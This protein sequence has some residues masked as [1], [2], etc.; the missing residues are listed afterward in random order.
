[1][2]TTLCL[3]AVLALAV[4]PSCYD[5]PNTTRKA[6]IGAATGAIIGGVIGHQSGETAA[7]AAVGA[8][9]GGAA[10]G[11]IGAQQ[12]RNRSTI[13]APTDRYGYTSNDYL[14]LLTPDEMETLRSRA[15]RDANVDLAAYL[16]ADEKAN[17]RRRASSRR[18]I[19]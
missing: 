11:A 4:M 3:L 18:T 16:T 17:L 19:G 14:N 10:G 12:D 5:R 1:M 2:K 8:A 6:G 15:P 7:G 9:V 13:D